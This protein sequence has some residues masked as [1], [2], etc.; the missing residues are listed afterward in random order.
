[1]AQPK[2]MSEQERI[3]K[4]E[5]EAAERK[6]SRPDSVFTSKRPKLA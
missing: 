1:M 5:M 2:K 4:A 6:R 3:M